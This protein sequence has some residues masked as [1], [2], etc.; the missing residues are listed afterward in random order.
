MT[1]TLTFQH[2]WVHVSPG[3]TETVFGDGSKV[4]AAPE[5]CAEYRAKAAR[6]GYAGDL[7]GLSREHE[8]LH[9][10]LSE[11]FGL[12]CSPTLWAVAHEQQGGVAPAWAQEEEE[13]LVLAFQIYLNSGERTAP[14]AA[15]EAHGL[16]AETLRQD[17]L[18]LLRAPDE[19]E[20]PPP[21]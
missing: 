21:Q 15:L 8:I 12:P 11:A 7:D 6:F 4:T 19:E 5:D 18:R 1:R 14:L 9:T 20:G 13:T 10:F 2:C 16:D 17:A 3:Y